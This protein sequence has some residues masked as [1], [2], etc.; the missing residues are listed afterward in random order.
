MTPVTPVPAGLSTRWAFHTART[1][2][3]LWPPVYNLQTVVRQWVHIT[4]ETAPKLCDTVVPTRLGGND[5]HQSPG[6]SLRVCAFVHAHTSFIES[7]T[8]GNPHRGYRLF[9]T[10]CLVLHVGTCSG[11]S[12][13]YLSNR[14]GGFS[15]ILSPLLFATSSSSPTGRRT[16][17]RE[18]PAQ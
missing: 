7:T 1:V 16:G 3:Q 4:R 13:G 17:P 8:A 9:V 6:L 2:K 12:Q 11:W 18:C 10:V 15:P 14:T 5:P